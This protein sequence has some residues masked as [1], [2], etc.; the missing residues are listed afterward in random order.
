MSDCRK[1]SNEAIS[2]LVLRVALILAIIAFAGVP[3]FSLTCQSQEKSA[4]SQ[5]Y[6]VGEAQKVLRAIDKIDAE[7]KQPRSGPLRD[8]GITE[9]ELHAYIAYRI[10]NDHEEIMKTLRL[11]LFPDNKVEGMIHVDLRGQKAPSFIRPEMDIFFAA[12]LLVANRAIKVDMKKLFVGN[13]PMQ[14][15]ILDTI[16]AISAALRKTEATSLNDWYQPRGSVLGWERA[17][18]SSQT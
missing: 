15:Y 10:E 11:K 6:N 5:A 3:L 7:S 4:P 1:Q 17:L 12:D 9:S 14:P 13:E 16:I 18:L 2:R 8:V